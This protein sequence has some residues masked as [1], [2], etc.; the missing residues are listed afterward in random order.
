MLKSISVQAFFYFHPMSGRQRSHGQILQPGPQADLGLQ[1]HG[2]GQ[3]QTQDGSEEGRQQ[4]SHRV[5]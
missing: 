5:V 3:V 2:Y 4:L 1:E